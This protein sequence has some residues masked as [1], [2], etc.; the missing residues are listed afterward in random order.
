MRG[1]KDSRGPT[2]SGHLP[3]KYHH[4]IVG[5]V[6]IT[7]PFINALHLCEYV[8][9]VKLREAISLFRCVT[10]VVMMYF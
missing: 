4:I 3:G 7:W 2:A 6:C 5:Y 8:C 10:L 1:V 9:G